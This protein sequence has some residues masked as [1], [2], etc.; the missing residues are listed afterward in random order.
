MHGYSSSEESDDP[1]RPRPVPASNNNNDQ[2]KKKKKKAP[3]QPSINHIWKRFQ[4]KKFNKALAVLPFDPVLP[5]ASSEKPNEL[6]TAGYERAA[7]ECRRKVKKIIQECRR[8]NMRYRDPGWD[9]DWDLKWEK[10]HCLNTLGHT[11]WQLS[12]ST[13]SNPNA[14]VPK[15][16]KRVHE[17]FE[18]PTFMKNING[19]D[20][21][22]GS[23]GD[24]WLMA[25]MT[26]LANV[27][28]GIER[29]CVEYDTRIGIYGFVFYRDGEW[30][31]SIIDDKLYLKSPCWDSPSMQRDLLQQIDREDVERVYR[32]TYQTGSKALFFAQCK[33]QNETWVPLL[34]KAYAKAHGDY[35]SLAGGWIGEG[36]EDLSGGVTTELLTSDILDID[37]FWENELSK[38]NEE[39]LFGCS[40]GLLDGGYGEREGISEGHAYVIMEARTLKSGERLIKLRN[41]WGKIR[42]GVWEGAW[43]DG[44]KEWTMEVQEELGHHFGNDSVFWINY[45][46]FLRKYQH[47]DRTRLFR[48]PAWR[49]A[50][51]WI[52]VDVPWK[53]Q[54][55]EKFQIKLTK[56]GPLCLV[57]SQLDNRYFKG[58]QGQYV[59]RIHFRIHE[60][61]RP[62]AEDYI[63]R[64]HGNYLMDRSVSIEL[65]DM[66]AGEYSIFM[67]V[68]GERDTNLPSVED[69]VKR[70]CRKRVENDKLVQVG[71][72]YD[73][74]H[75]K[76][77]AHLE[78]VARLRKIKEQQRASESRQKER[79]KLWER[80]H[81]NR[82]ITK[83]QTQKNNEKRDRKRAK[84]KEAA[85]KMAEEAKK[86]DEVA[87]KKAEEEEEAK[88]DTDA[89]NKAEAGMEKEEET[90]TTDAEKTNDQAVQT[91]AVQE[92]PK[93]A[94]PD[95]NV[96]GS[97]EE[98]E[99][100]KEETNDKPVSDNNP[101]DAVEG[102]S[103]TESKDEPKK[104]VADEKSVAKPAPA[105]EPAPKVEYDSAD[106]SSDSPIEDWE[107]LYSDDDMVRKPRL[108]P[109]GPPKTREERYESEEEG[110]PDPWNAV[111]IVG[112][113]VYSMDEDLEVRV[114][115]EGGELPEGGMG[116]KGEADLDNAQANAGGE[117]EKLQDETPSE[118]VASV[119]TNMKECD[120][121]DDDDAT[122]EANEDSKS[123]TSVDSDR[124]ANTDKTFDSS[125]YDKVDSGASTPEV[126]ATPEA[127]PLETNKELC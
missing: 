40:T 5:P 27:E 90:K 17:I 59:F 25:T 84:A 119:K 109:S 35:A 52:G 121:K 60:R 44:S 94:K 99:K 43:S 18:K 72:A 66:P 13:L 15:A 48:D 26:A 97:S 55:H 64:S 39:F 83:K 42:K 57:L 115:M 91:D 29:T 68:T 127:T 53:S 107:E 50:Q 4:D 58:L 61:G 51:R 105:P 54:F 6:L 86:E 78:E 56:D 126:I 12:R 7:E 20:V 106:D 74:A 110:L 77:A 63:V 124:S 108:T 67:S 89:K 33:D 31:Y 80:R 49:C 117:R 87:K 22:Q 62:G 38:V 70:E 96:A 123:E 37:G 1:R 47:I 36:L 104:D 103:K 102:D 75:S 34:E 120:Q 112:I 113:R 19:G 46:D 88:K 14:S 65:P 30:I 100:P 122:K 21:K 125:G 81:L 82:E 8:V 76:G 95:Q 73:L 9:L 2:K 71:S 41:P 69:V 23:L 10:G 92:V 118:T 16:V 28:G 93:E 101:K 32:K 85:M 11:K 111:C 79:R 116:K 3:P 45:D 98:N 24:C 114:V